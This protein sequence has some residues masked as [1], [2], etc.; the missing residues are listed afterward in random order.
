MCFC[1]DPDNGRAVKDTNINTFF[2]EP[3]CGKTGRKLKSAFVQLATR[4]QNKI[5]HNRSDKSVNV[6]FNCITSKLWSFPEHSK[7]TKKQTNKQTRK[8]TNKTRT[9]AKKQKY[10]GEQTYHQYGYVSRVW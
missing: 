5:A 6:L 10:K 4:L 7:E 3:R 9:L 1:V 8:Q 2:G